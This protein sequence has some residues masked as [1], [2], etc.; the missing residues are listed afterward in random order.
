MCQKFV[1]QTS[2]QTPAYQSTLQEGAFPSRK[3]ERKDSGD[4]REALDRQG[5]ASQSHT[6]KISSW[7]NSLPI[8]L[9]GKDPCDL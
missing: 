3:Q 6:S 4:L 1:T 5:H 8:L 2:S 9:V 7:P